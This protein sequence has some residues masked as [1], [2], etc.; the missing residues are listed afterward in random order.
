MSV[1]PIAGISSIRERMIRYA[2]P[3]CRRPLV[4][5]GDDLLCMHDGFR[6][7]QCNG[8]RGFLSAREAECHASFVEEYGAIR[9]AEGRGSDGPEHYLALPD[10][11]VADPKHEEWRMR[12]ESMRWLMGVLARHFAG[13]TLAIVDAGAGNCWLSRHLAEAGHEVVA[14]DVFA[15]ARDGL[16][17]GR[18]YLEHL[19]ISFDRV[20][21]D[22]AS[23]PFV[24]ACVDVVIY[25]GAFHYAGDMRGVLAEA[26]R[27]LRPGGLAII[28]DSPIY[29][30]YASGMKML[31]ERRIK[32]RSAF[33]TFAGLRLMA[34]ALAFE[35]EIDV[36][37]RSLFTRLKRR[38]A[39][40]RMGRE[41]ATMGRVVLKA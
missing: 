1:P 26:V 6:S 20:L 17:A 2:C 10:A 35:L 8:V 36:P 33:L 11:P 31:A 19:P 23:L 22:Y 38:L 18:H 15:D 4:E 37:R 13:R 29:S 27:V 14:L 34:D 16:A 39:E 41:V 25:N 9:S 5:D 24:N 28:L 40:V 12:G 32:G 21:A 3:T 7:R 30:D